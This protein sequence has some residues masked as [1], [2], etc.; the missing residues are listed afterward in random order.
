MFF[1]VPDKF[2]TEE[3][4]ERVKNNLPKYRSSNDFIVGYHKPRT[5]HDEDWGIKK[6]G[7]IIHIHNWET[8]NFCSPSHYKTTCYSVQWR[9]YVDTERI[10][11][12]VVNAPLV[13]N[14]D[15]YN[16]I[17]EIMVEENK[18]K[19]AGGKRKRKAI[20]ILVLFDVIFF[21]F[22]LSNRM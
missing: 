10:K 9:H 19:R 16:R 4:Y 15:Y 11:T 13:Y 8:C 20:C 5:V 2:I 22:L 17:Y 18:V 12:S 21:F 7:C 1:K 3:E 14:K 6:C